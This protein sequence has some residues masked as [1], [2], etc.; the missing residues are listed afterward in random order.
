MELRKFGHDLRNMLHFELFDIKKQE[1][2]DI[3]K[4]ELT[5][6]YLLKTNTDNIEEFI[7]KYSLM[8]NDMKII[9]SKIR[10]ALKLEKS[11]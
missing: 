7:T 4:L 11:F 8:R 6:L 10:D 1:Y 3:S 9:E 2:D 5:K